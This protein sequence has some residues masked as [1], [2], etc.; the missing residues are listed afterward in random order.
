MRDAGSPAMAHGED[1][2]EL[3]VAERTAVDVRTWRRDE[4]RAASRSRGRTDARNGCP[5]SQAIRASTDRG[6]Q[7]RRP[8]ATTG[9]QTVKQTRRSAFLAASAGAAAA[10]RLVRLPDSAPI[11]SASAPIAPTTW[12][13]RGSNS[14]TTR[15][16]RHSFR[17]ALQIAPALHIARLNLAIALLYAGRPAEAAP[18]ARAAAGT[19]LR[20]LRRRTTLLGLIAQGRQ[21]P[22]RGRSRIRTGAAA[23]SAR[24][25]RAD[26]A[27]PGAA[28]TP[29]LRRGAE[30]VPGGAGSRALQRHRRLQRGHRARARRPRR[31]RTARDAAVRGAA[32]T[33]HTA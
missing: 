8:R 10:C 25:R 12:A 22:G 3:S 6:R 30:T 20:K 15:E 24:C 14:S 5:A 9:D 4:G 17:E 7:R 28:A 1:R 29:P 16:R 21:Q 31:R 19:T 27:R 2:I 13:S 18:E 33:A 11:A 26:P 32:E 23:R